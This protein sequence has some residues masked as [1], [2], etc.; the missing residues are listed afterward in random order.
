MIPILASVAGA[1]LGASASKVTA[2]AAIRQAG[3]LLMA[4]QAGGSLTG[5]ASVG[6]LEP[7]ALIDDNL[8][9]NPEVVSPLANLCQSIIT[10]Y[11][12]RAVSLHNISIGGVSIARQLEPYNT[13]RNAGMAAAMAM[14]A[15]E[16][17]EYQDRLVFENEVRPYP[18]A[19][20]EEFSGGRSSFSVGNSVFTRQGNGTFTRTRTGEIKTINIQPMPAL[21]AAGDLSNFRMQQPSGRPG[22][23][24]IEDIAFKEVKSMAER[25]REQ[26]DAAK[27]G[28]LAVGSVD[29]AETFEY[30]Q[31]ADVV[32]AGSLVTGKLVNVT[33]KHGKESAVVPVGVRLNC[34]WVGSEALTAVLG[35]AKDVRTGTRWKQMLS[36]EISWKDMVTSQD[37]LDEHKRILKD[38]KSGIYLNMLKRRQGNAKAALVSGVPSMNTASSVV[39]LSSEAAAR[40]ELRAG[41][42]LS[43]YQFRQRIFQHGYAMIMAIVNTRMGSVTIYTRDIPDFTELDFS[44]LKSSS[45]RDGPDIGDIL[46]AFRAGNSMRL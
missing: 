14:S 34:M 2:M 31:V 9:R 20:L 1:A 13:H 18:K 45:K 4:G 11:F 41:G 3:K 43:D 6:R 27:T 36:G 37:L 5:Y 24:P 28:A 25:F 8:R 46:S 21:E 16:N 26:A 39:I 35:G 23:E 44:E 33:L 7:V 40:L 29:G 15:L 22:P 10:A 17:N 30:K 32:D 19:A 42:F 12:L 38:D